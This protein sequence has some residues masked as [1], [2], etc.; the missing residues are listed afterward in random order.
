M[1]LKILPLVALT[2]VLLFAP[3]V[4][5]A[6]YICVENGLDDDLCE[7]TS[8]WWQTNG[9]MNNCEV[10]ERC[11]LGGLVCYTFCKLSDPCL[12][13][14]VMTSPTGSYDAVCTA[15]GERLLIPV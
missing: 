11:L 1:R 5:S 10:K 4:S 9:G 12:D 8:N 13:T 3:T 14:V 15:R 2:I 7:P 6:C